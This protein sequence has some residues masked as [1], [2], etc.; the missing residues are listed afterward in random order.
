M[1]GGSA[2]G[3][4]AA[5]GGGG[6]ATGGGGAATGGGGSATGGGGSATGGGGGSTNH[7]GGFIFTGPQDSGS[8]NPATSYTL[9]TTDAGTGPAASIGS[10]CATGDDCAALGA[11]AG[12]FTNGDGGFCTTTCPGESDLCDAGFGCLRGIYTDNSGD[13][14]G[15][16]LPECASS[17]DCSGHGALTTCSGP[18]YTFEPGFPLGEYGCYPGCTT[19]ADCNGLMCNP[20]T[21]TCVDPNAYLGAQCQSDADCR[22]LGPNGTCLTDERNPSNRYCTRWCD[23]NSL[24]GEPCIT[25]YA[26]LPDGGVASI[27]LRGCAQDSD[28]Q[29]ASANTCNY[30]P[31]ENQAYCSVK[32]SSDADCP[33]GH[34]DVASGDCRSNGGFW[35]TDCA[36]GNNCDTGLCVNDFHRQGKSNCTQLCMNDGECPSG[37]VCVFSPVAIDSKLY[38]FFLSIDAGFCAPGC[39]SDGGTC[40]DPNDSCLAPHDPP[41][42][43]F[44]GSGNAS[45]HFCWR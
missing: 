6:S 9:L 28:C 18:Y 7:D 30:F 24:T 13:M 14:I 34:C 22:T 17:A 21:S 23:L 19:D 35:A 12:C 39:A 32:C 11:G 31:A 40:S 41:E 3:G 5:T 8:F 45:G 43:D 37:A 4:G 26:T 20:L 16:C 42:I 15:L 25:G 2:T 44:A 27:E 36:V 1:G 33:D 29:L 38:N 10:P